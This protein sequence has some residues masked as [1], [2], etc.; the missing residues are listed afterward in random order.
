MIVFS[1]SLD[2]SKCSTCLG[3]LPWAL[4]PAG[5]PVPFVPFPSVPVLAG[6]TLLEA[7]AFI[8]FLDL[9]SLELEVLESET[10]ESESLEFGLELEDLDLVFLRFFGTLP[11]ELGVPVTDVS[12]GV[13][14]PGLVFLPFFLK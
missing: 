5:A 3:P 6:A 1:Y 4:A 14:D 2:L 12:L 8:D 10:L 11:L 9:E 13:P 7:P